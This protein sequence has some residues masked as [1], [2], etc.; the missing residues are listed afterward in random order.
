MTYGCI[1][2]TFQ[3]C[4][5]KIKIQHTWRNVAFSMTCFSNTTTTWRRVPHI[6]NRNNKIQYHNSSEKNLL[7]FSPRDGCGRREQRAKRNCWQLLLS[8]LSQITSNLCT[9]N[10]YVLWV[11]CWGGKGGR[12]CGAGMIKLVLWHFFILC[13]ATKAQ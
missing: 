2:L 1:K 5:L 7:I 11:C 4:I 9:H 13:E 8:L 12:G 3:G 6:K 10:R